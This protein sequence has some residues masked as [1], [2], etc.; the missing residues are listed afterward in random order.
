MRI[1]VLGIMLDLLGI[2]WLQISKARWL[3]DH[4]SACVGAV[5]WRALHR[6]LSVR[7]VR[8]GGHRG[9]L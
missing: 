1:R 6:C 2:T 8:F 7:N 9:S 4:W 5:A 3:N